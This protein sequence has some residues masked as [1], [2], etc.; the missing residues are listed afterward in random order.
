[1][2]YYRY[3]GRLHSVP[4]NVSNPVLAYDTDAFAAAGLDPERPP[5]TFAEVERAAQQLVTE[6]PTEYGI[7]FA[8]YSWFVEQWF[9]QANEP[10]VEPVMAATGGL[11]EWLTRPEQQRR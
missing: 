9:A 4:F 2:N 10:L 11:L 3:G 7:T 8:N 1:V 6:G 5:A